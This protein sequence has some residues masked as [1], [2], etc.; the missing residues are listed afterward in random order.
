VTSEGGGAS[1]G[2]FSGLHSDALSKMRAHN[3][4]QGTEADES[5]VDEWAGRGGSGGLW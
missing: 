3:T 2:G 5:R 4:S 1:P